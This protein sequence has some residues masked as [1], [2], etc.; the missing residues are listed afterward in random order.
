LRFYDELR[1]IIRPRSKSDLTCFHRLSQWLV[2]E[3][4]FKR[5]DEHIFRRV[6]DIARESAMGSRNPAAVFM[7]RLKKE[8]N[9]QPN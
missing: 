9:Y 4:T 3:I 1:E 7:S 8:L 6:L 2:K 5:F